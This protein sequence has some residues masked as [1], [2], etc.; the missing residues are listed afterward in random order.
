[1]R[2]RPSMDVQL[3]RVARNY[4]DRSYR[5]SLGASEILGISK[6]SD[7]RFSSSR[8]RASCKTTPTT[9]SQHDSF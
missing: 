2:R 7:R 3:K 8:S 4:L 6:L 5:L 9:K 1:M